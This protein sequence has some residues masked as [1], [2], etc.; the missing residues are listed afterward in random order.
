M[1]TVQIVV[2]ADDLRLHDPPGAIR[3]GCPALRDGL[4]KSIPDGFRRV[5][6]CTAEAPELVQRLRRSANKGSIRPANRP[7]QRYL[8][9]T[10]VPAGLRPRAVCRCPRRPRGAVAL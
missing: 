4:N 5:H 8:P 1:E 7:S 3:D 6:P 10:A 2:V 9:L